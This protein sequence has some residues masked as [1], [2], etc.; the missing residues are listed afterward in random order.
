MLLQ[1]CVAFAT[2]NLSRRQAVIKQ[3][4]RCRSLKTRSWSRCE[5][6]KDHKDAASCRDGVG[7]PDELRDDRCVCPGK[8]TTEKTNEIYRRNRCEASAIGAPLKKLVGDGK[9][10]DRSTYGTRQ[11]SNDGDKTSRPSRSKSI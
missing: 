6:H 2:I 10:T 8:K 9:E 5:A 1:T 11:E 4:K 3:V 7:A